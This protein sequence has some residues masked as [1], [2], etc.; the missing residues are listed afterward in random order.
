MRPPPGGVPPAGRRPRRGPAGEACLAR[1]ARWSARV[2]YADGSLPAPLV[3][4]LPRNW[5]HVRALYE[6]TGFRHTAGD[7]EA[8]LI[9][10]VAGLPDREPRPGG[11][12]ERTLGEYG[13]ASWSGRR[14]GIP[15]VTSRSTR[16][17]PAR[18][19]A[20]A[21]GPAGIGNL[22]IDPE[23]AAASANSAPKAPRSSAPAWGTAAPAGSQATSRSTPY[24]RSRSAAG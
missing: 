8:I 4:G 21:A 20:R 6:G 9:A 7:T 3:H 17:R 19:H 11:T 14:E 18:S 23:P 1:F 16:H 10:Q 22:S 24:S 12:A 13:P 5:P 15:S 2:R